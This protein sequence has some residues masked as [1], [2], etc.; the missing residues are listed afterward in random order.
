MYQRFMKRVNRTKKL[1]LLLACSLTAVCGFAQTSGTT[2]SLTWSVSDNT[3]TISGSGSMP[4]YGVGNSPWNS[5]RHAIRTIII[6]ENVTSIGNYAFFLC[7]SLTSITIPNSVTSIGGSAF[8]A[9]GLTSITIPK[10]VASVENNAFSNCTR[11]TSINVDADNLNYASENGVLFNKAKTTLLIYPAGKTENLYTLPNSVATIKSSAFFN[12]QGLTSITIPNSVTSVEY[13]AFLYCYNFTSINVD[14]DNLNYASENGILFNKA[15][16]TLLLCPVGKTGDLNTLPN[17]VT[18]IEREAFHGCINLTSITI[19][20]SVKSIGDSPFLGCSGLTELTLPFVG[21]SAT[22]TGSYALFGSLF[23]TLSNSEMQAVTQYYTSNNSATYYLPK[24]LKKITLTS[25]CSTISYGAFY[26]CTMLEE[27]VLPNSLTSIGNSAFYNCTSIASITIPISVTSIGGSAFSGCRSI[28]ISGSG[29]MPNYSSSSWNNI[30]AVIIDENVTSISNSAFSG[31]SRLTSITIPESVTSIG[32][33]AFSGCTNLKNLYVSWANPISI[34][35]GS[36]FLGLTLSSINLHVP[37]G[38]FSAYLNHTYWNQFNIQGNTSWSCPNL[39]ASG[40]AQKLT[41]AICDSTLIISGNESMPNYTSGSTPWYAYRNNIKS[42][43]INANVISIG[44]YAFAGCANLTSIDIP[45]GVT[46][47]GSNV[48]SGCAKLESINVEA[49]NPNYTSENGILFN[50][51][52]T[53]LIRYPVKKEGDLYTPPNSVTSI[54]DYAFDG[55]SNLVSVT[56]PNNVTSIGSA[57]FSGCGRLT[58]ITISGSGAM[59]NYS[60]SLWYNITTVIIEENVTSI[61]NSAFSG[62]AD[63]TSITIP[64]S[65]TSIG[66]S[67][68]SGCTGLTS[69]T[70]PN[71]VTSIGNSS[72]YRCKPKKVTTPFVISDLFT[73]SLEDLTITSTCVNIPSGALAACK[74]LQE[75][76]LPFIG[77]SHAN[78]TPLS[79]LFSGTAPTTLTKLTLVRSATEIQIADN[80]LSGCSNLTELTLSSN[81]KGLGENTLYGCSGLRHIYS[82]WA[83]PPVAYNSSTFQGVNK[84]TCT[85]YVPMGSKQYYSVADGWIEFFAP[86]D[87]IQEEAAITIIARSV[88]R[89]GGVI[90]GLLQHNYDA[91]AKLTAIG[92]TGYDFQGWM[93]NNQIVSTDREFTF[94]VEAP[95][96]LYAIFTPGEN[97]DKNIQVK[98]HGNSASI[99]WVAVEDAAN[100]TLI[101]YSDENRTQEIVRF[102]LDDEGNISRSTVRNLS[103]VIP[104][105]DSATSYYYSLASY[106]S[107]SQALTIS[108]GNFTTT[109]IGIDIPFASNQISIYPNP[110]KDDIFIKSD[111]Q[112]S[113]VEIYS[114]AG[115]LLLSKNN[116]DESVSVATLPTGIYLLKAYTDKGAAVSRIVKE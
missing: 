96:T 55:C 15:K 19:P 34:E 78:P 50:K 98:E 107:D 51:E 26:N 105:L 39:I 97:A 22:A 25:P 3:L 61:S 21:T 24:N 58:S 111:L 76:T 10:N 16:T 108:N 106:D 91:E 94:I 49:D 100:Y 1:F 87:N 12:C 115:S 89:Y 52:K 4:N 17:S 6:E 71:S 41:W 84:F 37:Q 92:N 27:I 14:A 73:S 53:T 54:G 23:S 82:H 103:C 67:A 70:I 68:F 18:S 102:G 59:P 99:S 85:L 77:T 93:D 20:E 47:V 38:A 66:N 56:I 48:F 74:N 65:V 110:A 114:L 95:R 45:E 7:S 116:I 46:R 83:Y 109:T 36:Q 101:I 81:V 62:C 113:R 64:N 5:I 35:S 88:P 60:S 104:N 72:F 13:R 112:I 75:L 86:V 31:C 44:N 69:I 2:G 11:L 28:I 9:C 8:N 33:F 30:T 29:A 57:A 40:S 32:S 43:E 63:L 80:A 90:S 42:V 79:T